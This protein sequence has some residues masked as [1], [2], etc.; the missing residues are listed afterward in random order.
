MVFADQEL[1]TYLQESVS[2]GHMGG[3]LVLINRVF[4]IWK[5][6]LPGLRDFVEMALDHIYLFTEE[7][8]S[9]ALMFGGVWRIWWCG[10]S[11][12]GWTI[13]S[14]RHTGDIWEENRVLC[15]C[16]SGRQ[17]SPGRRDFCFRTVGSRKFSV[18]ERAVRYLIRDFEISIVGPPR[19]C[20][21]RPGL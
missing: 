16:L 11:R 6:V 4:C 12:G 10:S 13:S 5:I 2:C 3:G 7:Q 9:I 1:I 14:P 19:R 18:G 8:V 20:R 21:K 15:W 17:K